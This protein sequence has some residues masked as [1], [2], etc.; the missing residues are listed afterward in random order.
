[1]YYFGLFLDTL[2]HDGLK[3]SKVSQSDPYVKS[4]H[5]SSGEVIA[6]S[7]ELQALDV[8]NQ[9]RH[10]YVVCQFALDLLINPYTDSCEWSR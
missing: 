1:M 7:S 8:S 4:L 6:T 10:N 5:F 3:S 2:L 9:V